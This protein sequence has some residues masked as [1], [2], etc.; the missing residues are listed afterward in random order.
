M[1]MTGFVSPLQFINCTK[2][3]ALRK[4]RSLNFFISKQDIN[5]AKVRLKSSYDN[6]TQRIMAVPPG[7][8]QAFSYKGN[9]LYIRS[10]YG[11]YYDII[12]DELFFKSDYSYISVTGTPGIGKSMFYMYFFNR[13]RLENP[14]KSVIAASFGKN[15]DLLDCTLFRHNGEVE[16]II[17]SSANH[18]IPRKKTF[19]WPKDIDCD[20]YLYDGPPKIKPLDV[21]MV[22]FTS[23]NFSWLDSMRKDPNHVTLYMPTWHLNELLDANEEL[24]LNIN[25]K[26]LMERYALFGGSA[27][28]CLS[29]SETF[30]LKGKQEIQNAMTKIDSFDQLRDLYFGTTELKNVVHRVMH[31]VPEEDPCFAKLLPATDSISRMLVE[32]LKIKLNDNRRILMMWL[33]GIQK[34]SSFSGFLFESY[35]HERLM[36]GG[37]F[38]IRPLAT[39]SSSSFTI[40]INR[41]V[42][43][44]TRFKTKFDQDWVYKDI[45]RMPE[46]QTFPSI[47]SYILTETSVLM[48]QIT[49]SEK[50]PVKSSGL[51]DLLRAMGKL[52]DKQGI[53]SLAQLIFV[54]PRGMGK[55]YRSQNIVFSALEEGNLTT[56]GCDQ[57]PGIRSKTI[58]KELGI[59]NCEQLI[60]AYHRGD[61][62]VDFVRSI[63]ES[64]LRNKLSPAE[65]EAIKC[66]PQYVIE[67]DYYDDNI[68]F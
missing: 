13:Y 8:P 5:H 60:E 12:M 48:F 38:E 42:G 49:R 29:T 62:K 64:W 35:V 61:E 36:D 66:I 27:R 51:I 20:M 11:Q 7:I 56:I 39:N 6:E 1:K 37:K 2:P 14:G 53:T 46:D 25:E 26:E 30:V 40:A 33:D 18:Y 52:N 63:V 10:C 47:D 19:S 54:V 22:A 45:Y 55:N 57:F 28:Y 67:I 43:E 41:T 3:G 31:Y 32:R 21:K 4:I 34:G 9:K 50:H 65:L 44:Y 15:Q 16:V 24:E 58:L 17:D 68:K 59:V 23:P